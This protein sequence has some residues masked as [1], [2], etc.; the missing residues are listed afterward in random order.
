MEK[1]IN[2]GKLMIPLF[3][4]TS[5]IF[6]ESIIENG[7]GGRNPIKDLNIFDLAKE[8]Y[9]LS[10]NFLKDTKL[11]EVS[12]FSLGQMVKQTSESMNFQHGDTYLSPSQKTAIKYVIGDPYTR[13]TNKKL[14][15]GSELLTYTLNFMM[16]II[17]KEIPEVEDDLINRFPKVYNFLKSWPSPIVIELND[18]PIDHLLSESGN[19]PDET[20]KKIQ[21]AFDKD[22]PQLCQ[23][24]NFRLLQSVNSSE[25]KFWLINDQ[26]W[27]TETEEFKLYQ[28][29]N[30]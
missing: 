8:V 22:M 6:L 9:N 20:L 14:H 7:L 18:V 15:Y 5:T 13:L 11:Y 23:Q 21:F 10:E 4:G 16:E 28:I 26:Q 25:L 1:I 29:M 17:K 30:N 19:D 24:Y 3:H 27:D 2:N 12:H